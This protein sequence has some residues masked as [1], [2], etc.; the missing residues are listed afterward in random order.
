MRHSPSH[1][2]FK[3]PN[4]IV[5][6]SQ[7]SSFDKDLYVAYQSS[8]STQGTSSLLLPQP[9]S[10]LG[11]PSRP[12]S[13]PSP[14]D[15][16]GIIPDSQSLPG[17]CSYRPGSS[18]SLAVLGADQAPLTQK[19]RVLQNSTDLESSSGGFI[20]LNDSIE[21]SSAVVIEATQPSAL[22]SERC[23]SEPAPN[24]TQRS[25]ESPFR[26]QLRSLPRSTSDPTSTYE[27]RRQRRPSVSEYPSDPIIAHG[28]VLQGATDFQSPHQTP[29]KYTQQRQ[30]SS[31]V[32]V[33]GSDDRSSTQS[34]AVDGSPV[35]SLV[36]Q[37]QI[38]LAFASQG[39][40]VS[41]APAGTPRTEPVLSQQIHLRTTT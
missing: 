2:P 28:Q 18:T 40:R 17:S 22:G 7:H 16:N 38:P 3:P 24:T 37:T 10:A 30:R 14:V 26:A 34:H 35:H 13:T 31:E 11:E 6:I 39:S 36:F 1:S 21:D 8:L 5:R 15:S 27:G 12:S 23:R 4:I 32:Q 29:V 41:I 25:S 9:N 33:P 19:S 20:E